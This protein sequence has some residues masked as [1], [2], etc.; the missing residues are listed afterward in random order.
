M[1]GSVLRVVSGLV[2]ALAL[3][4][5]LG[6]I[7]R[8]PLAV[9]Q[10]GEHPIRYITQALLPIAAF[11][12]PFALAAVALSEARRVRG[13]V[14]WLFVGTLVGILGFIAVSGGP[15][16]TRAAFQNTRTFFALCAMGFAAG[17]AY[18]WV[19]GRYAGR[20]ARS[21]AEAGMGHDD[22][23]NSQRRCWY[24]ALTGLALALLPLVL[25]GW[26]AIYRPAPML[27]AALVRKA[28][29]DA[30]LQLAQAGVPN[31]ALII[32]DHIGR[33]TGRA[34]DQS[35]RANAFETARRVLAPM[36]GL[37][38]IVAYL[39]NDISVGEP[40]RPTPE[41]IAA[42]EAEAAAR[43]QAD[44]AAKRAEAETAA[45][46]AA[47]KVAEAEAAAKAAEDARVAAQAAIERKTTEEI[48]AAEA[49]AAADAEAKKAAD[50]EA[51][52]KA[53]IEA[54]AAAAKAEADKKAA[55]EAESQA[56]ELAEQKAAEDQARGVA[57][58]AARDK[59]IEEQRR[60]AEAEDERKAV[61]AAHAAEAAAKAKADADAKAAAAADDTSQ[62]AEAC[63]GE[64]SVLFR[65]D[66]IRFDLGSSELDAGALSFIDK[67]AAEAKQCTGFTVSVYG[68]TDRTGD[69]AANK[70]ISLERA[71]RVADALMARGIPVSRIDV[72]AFGSERP[73]SP[74]N[75]RATYA[76]N[77]RVD[78]GAAPSVASPAQPAAPQVSKP[79]ESPAPP[80]TAPAESDA[81][82]KADT[83]AKSGTPGPI[84]V[85][86]GECASEFGRLFLSET[87][88]FNGSSAAIAP[89]YN[90]FLDRLAQL[91]ASCPAYV[92]TIDGHTDR[93]GREA[94][95][96]SLSEARAGAVRAALVAR[97]V[98]AARLT[99][100]GYAGQRPFDPANTAAAYAQNRR[101]D[102]GYAERAP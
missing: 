4:A 40:G 44:E 95:N 99:T 18:W 32:S 66:A 58:Q 63:A 43:R 16:D 8:V 13:L 96:Q 86:A 65:S 93:R 2:L 14:F 80:P 90:G 20:L 51:K 91:A 70:M 37:P 87:I 53:D 24:C 21:L 22:E 55:A 69:E 82:A 78:F 6:L 11:G 3:S 39:Q 46:V 26:Y 62:V 31:L 98:A 27:P 49:K 75:N 83:E 34:A 77:R 88:R 79:A 52:R 38:G 41:A 23:A 100:H 15:V 54:A 35:D 85:P 64:F 57:E 94:V 60:I 7:F 12:L 33:V 19:A 89:S 1:R 73:F 92:L 5:I 47:Q 71:Q 101:V 36:V 42:A 59:A 97:G 29:A 28:E 10:P 9:W 61:D 76:L 102:F 68:H 84:A 48:K 45:R 50:A 17:F 56:R 25:L 74:A 81:A 72:Q 30:S 67:I